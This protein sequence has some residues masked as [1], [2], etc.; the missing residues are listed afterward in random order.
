MTQS[1]IIEE[2]VAP[3]LVCAI[4]VALLLAIIAAMVAE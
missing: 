1:Q 4:L 3:V 2:W